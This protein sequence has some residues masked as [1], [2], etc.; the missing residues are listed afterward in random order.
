MPMVNSSFLSR[1]SLLEKL[2]AAGWLACAEEG[3]NQLAPFSS[4]QVGGNTLEF[5]LQIL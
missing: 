2:G 5:F 1:S 4:G 3:L